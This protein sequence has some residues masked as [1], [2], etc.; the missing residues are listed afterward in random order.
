[1]DPKEAHLTSAI[2]ELEA[3]IK[4]AEDKI[5]RNPSWPYV[6]ILIL[7]TSPFLHGGKFGFGI[8]GFCLGAGVA[9][10]I[11]RY[12]QN[13]PLHQRI[14]ANRHRLMFLHKMLEAHK[15]NPSLTVS[16]D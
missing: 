3:S 15:A 1:M 2:K 7:S 4:E 6:C 9:C 10:L 16:L 13:W 11:N 5:Q 12:Y 14:K 8:G